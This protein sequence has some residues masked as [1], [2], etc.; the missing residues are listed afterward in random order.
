MADTFN[1]FEL[2]RD[3][4]VFVAAIPG[5]WL[6]RHSTTSWR[7]RD[8]KEGFQRMVDE[9]RARAIAAAVLAQNR[10]F[11]N[12]IVLATNST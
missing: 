7:I 6:L 3:P 1:G 5:D 2:Q 4:G 11:P 10:T 8:P 12:A 9:R